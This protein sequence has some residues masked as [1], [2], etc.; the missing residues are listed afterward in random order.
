MNNK[1]MYKKTIQI[2]YSFEGDESNHRCFVYDDIYF[3]PN[4]SNGRNFIK[5]LE[6]DTFLQYKNLII[7]KYKFFTSAFSNRVGVFNIHLPISEEELFY[8][9]LQGYEDEL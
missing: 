4:T 7:Q 8:M 5:Y 6:D 2:Y 3:V 9:R 1:N